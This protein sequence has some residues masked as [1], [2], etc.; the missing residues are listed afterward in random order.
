MTRERERGLIREFYATVITGS[1]LSIAVEPTSNRLL[2]ASLCRNATAR[3]GKN[4]FSV[5]SISIS[6]KEFSISYETLFFVNSLNVD[7]AQRARRRCRTKPRKSRTSLALLEWNDPL[8]AGRWWW[9]SRYKGC[10]FKGRSFYWCRAIEQALKVLG[11]IV[12]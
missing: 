5:G 8:G 7:E 1:W 12:R 11:C 6:R 2:P 4:R 3:E 10:S 9:S